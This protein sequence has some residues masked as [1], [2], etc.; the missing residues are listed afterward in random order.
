MIKVF[1][2]TDK[3]FNSNGDIVIQPFKAKVHKKDN[4]DYYL[5]IETSLEYIDH[6]VEGNIIVA[7]APSPTGIKDQAFRIGNVEKTKSKITSK[8]LHVYYDSSNYLIQSAEIE[9]KTCAEALNIL[10][11]STRPVSEFQT[12]SDVSGTN[13]LSIDK[14]SL[15]E[16]ISEVISLYGGHLIR[17][18]FTIAIKSDI[19]QDNGVIVQYKKNLKEITCQENWDSVVTDLLPVG[20][21]GIMLNTL[22]PSVDPYL[23][24][25]IQYPI[26]YTKTVQFS[27]DNINSDDYPSESAYKQALVADLRQVATAYLQ[28]NSLPQI[29]YTLKA[30]LDRITDIGDIVEVIDDRLGI[31]MIT[32][33]IGFEYDCIA[34]K[35]TEVEFGNFTQSLSDL[36]SNINS[37]TKEIAVLQAQTVQDSINERLDKVND[38]V[39]GT[40]ETNGWKW[41]KWASGNVQTWRQVSIDA[42]T[43]TWSSLVSGLSA[44]TAS[45]NLPFTITSPMAIATMDS[46]DVKGWVA[47]ADCGSTACDLTLVQ[48]ST[49]GTSIVTI[50]VRGTI[51]L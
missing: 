25:T 15:N 37:S 50:E 18:N 8:C 16:A 14:K 26:P 20:K 29:N 41:M 24:S 22:D 12:L 3:V 40:G 4:A 35:Y 5:D 49:T 44:G 6:I 2:Q 10:N 36:L 31:K 51:V 27:Q 34:G 45:V 11:T 48:S 38:Y 33:V 46:C 17:D 28:E 7:P 43:L 32:A 21:D 47:S 30:N 9:N 13:S 23:Q 42:T 19:G 39:I 1:G